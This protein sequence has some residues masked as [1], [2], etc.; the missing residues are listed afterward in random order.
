[1]EFL[2]FL[3]INYFFLVHI[4]EEDIV[5]EPLSIKEGIKLPSTFVPVTYEDFSNWK[6]P[7]FY[8]NP[9]DSKLVPKYP[10][11]KV[12]PNSIGTEYS[13]EELRA[14]RY[15][16]SPK[17]RRVVPQIETEQAVQSI[18]GETN[19]HNSASALPS[20]PQTENQQVN[21][22]DY[23]QQ[24]EN[25][26]EYNFHQQN[27]EN[28]PHQSPQPK[29]ENIHHQNLY[30]QQ[31]SQF[32]QQNLSQQHLHQQNIH[33]QNIQPSIMQHSFHQQN[34]SQEVQ[35][36]QYVFQQQQQEY[37]MQH[38]NSLQHMHQVCGLH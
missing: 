4:D 11:A 16:K 27:I 34:Y 10:K 38:Q 7:L 3:T 36:N 30:H 13:L 1:M 26:V 5:S 8:P 33:Q 18:L 14:L 2:S 6:I 35:Q 21:K 20:F 31:N 25:E 12:Y 9:E 15:L 17:S 28:I 22:Q 23:M 24:E 19:I 32:S 29:N 37:D